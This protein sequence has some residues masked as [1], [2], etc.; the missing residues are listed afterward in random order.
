MKSALN[1]R[2]ILLIMQ[3]WSI[4]HLFSLFFQVGN[5]APNLGGSISA[6]SATTDHPQSPI[7]MDPNV[8]DPH[9]FYGWNYLQWI[10]Y[11]WRSLKGLSRLDY[12]NGGGPRSNDLILRLGI[13]NIHRTGPG[14]GIPQ[15]LTWVIIM[16]YSY[17]KEIGMTFSWKK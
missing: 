1:Y 9:R 17:A 3:Q 4:K 6:V 13:M 7:S 14:C 8:V 12:I 16:F 15:L 11:I 2:I 5:R 10:Q